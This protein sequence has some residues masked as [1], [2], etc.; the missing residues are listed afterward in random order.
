[1]MFVIPLLHITCSVWTRMGITLKT[2]DHK[3]KT[4]FVCRFY[5]I[6]K[7][8]S[9]LKG[10]DFYIIRLYIFERKPYIYNDDNVDI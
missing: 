2:G 7:L 6:L 10:T 3:I 9:I 1:M 8:K 5:K 4:N